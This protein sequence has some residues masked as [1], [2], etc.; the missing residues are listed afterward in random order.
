MNI[1]SELLYTITRAYDSII[2]DSFLV[3]C[4]WGESCFYQLLVYLVVMWEYTAQFVIWNTLNSLDNRTNVRYIFFLFYLVQL[5]NE[6]KALTK[7]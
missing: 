2:L 1:F 5:L 4:K 7:Q 3:I 6:N